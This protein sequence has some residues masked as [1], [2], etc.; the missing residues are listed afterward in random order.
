MPECR[1]AREDRVVPQRLVKPLISGATYRCGVHLLLG[2]V[3]ALPY[4][5]LTASFALVLA[6]EPQELPWVAVLLLVTLLIALTPAFLAG[7]RSL[8]ISAAREVLGADVP[9]PT[10]AVSSATRL[11]SALWFVVHLLSGGVLAVVL[12]IAVPTAL[13]FILQRFGSDTQ[14]VDTSGLGFLD[15]V[16]RWWLLVLGIGLLLAIPYGTAAAGVGLRRLAP[17]LLG[18]SPE[19][20][21]A[22]LEAHARSLAERNRLARDLHDSVGHAL[23]ITTV[24]AAAAQQVGDTDPAFV[25]R[26]LAA[27]EEAGR[28]AMADLD[29]VLGLLRAG[30]ANSSA[31]PSDMAPQRGLADLPRLVEEARA[32]GTKISSDLA[33]NLD[34]VPTAVSRE[35][36]RIVQEALTNAIRHAGGAPVDL[37]VQRTADGLRIDVTNPLPT[38]PTSPPRVQTASGASDLGGRGLTGMAERVRVLGGD[39]DTGRRDEMWTVSAR[40]PGSSAGTDRRVGGRSRDSSWPGSGRRCGRTRSGASGPAGHGPDGRTDARHRRNRRDAAHTVHSGSTTEGIGDHHL[41]ERR[42]CL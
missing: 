4:V 17:I 24:Q 34:S 16:D 7:V 9:L 35:G 28:T 32:A 20:R 37:R 40:L 41:R 31:A 11:R 39:L 13:V 26:A 33:P 42:L 36:Y 14:I 5:L 12:L 10:G 21:I 18:P 6:S 38:P 1:A 3:I 30:E 25:A 19:E 8:E 15:G 22:A 29:H 2:A 27:I 23:T